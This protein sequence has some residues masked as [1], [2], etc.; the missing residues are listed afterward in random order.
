MLRLK[1]QKNRNLQTKPAC[2]Q[3]KETENNKT[4]LGLLRRRRCSSGRRSDATVR[5]RTLE[6]LI[7]A[8]LASSTNN[9]SYN[10]VSNS[11]AT[12]ERPT[13]RAN[14]NKQN[15]K[16]SKPIDFTPTPAT[17]SRETTSKNTNTHDYRYA[18]HSFVVPCSAFRCNVT[19]SSAARGR[20]K[21]NSC[22]FDERGVFG[23]LRLV[24]QNRCDFLQS[25]TCCVTHFFHAGDSRSTRTN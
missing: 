11:C 1:K 15:K 8:P 18:S 5:L 22:F 19:N 21:H 14:R 23:R 24:R 6:T 17:A 7:D 4:N 25:G 9:K 12:A 20:A 3:R 2:F 16:I 10:R 13:N